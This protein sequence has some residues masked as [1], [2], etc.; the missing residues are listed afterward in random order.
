MVNEKAIKV[1]ELRSGETG[2]GIARMDP[3][4]M[5]I[6]GIRTGD[7][8]QID[9]SKKTAVKILMIIPIMVSK[10]IKKVKTICFDK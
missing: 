5:D 3:E 7:I 4:L 1:A 9:G 2:K 10:T 6:M 8:V